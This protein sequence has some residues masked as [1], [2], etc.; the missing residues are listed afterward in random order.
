M[1]AA[2][3]WDVVMVTAWLG[4]I[5]WVFHTKRQRQAESGVRPGVSKQ[6]GSNWAWQ[7]G[8]MGYECFR[9]GLR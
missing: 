6:L 4:F 7:H 3:T 5:V 1:H 8:L 2:V 9:R